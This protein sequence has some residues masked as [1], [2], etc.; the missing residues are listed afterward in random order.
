M[1]SSFLTIPSNPLLNRCKCFAP[2]F[3][4]PGWLT[5]ASKTRYISPP[6]CF[7]GHTVT[8]GGSDRTWPP[9]RPVRRGRRRRK[10]RRTLRRT[11][12]SGDVSAVR[13]PPGA[14]RS[15]TY[16][17]AFFRPTISNDDATLAGESLGGLLSYCQPEDQTLPASC[18][19]SEAEASRA[20]SHESEKRKK[21]QPIFAYKSL[22]STKLL[23]P[24]RSLATV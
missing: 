18:R 17:R 12:P 19:P 9:A 15:S 20:H 2:R 23:S 22:V 5:N 11:D 3:G 24:A 4:H 6:T 1:Y 16:C 13:A 7:D 10:R 21:A 14:C 8:Q